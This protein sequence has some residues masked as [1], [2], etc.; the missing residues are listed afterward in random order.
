MHGYHDM[1]NIKGI[2][3]MTPT[4]DR[5]P[6]VALFLDV[7]G[8]LTTKTYSSMDQIPKTAEQFQQAT[9]FFNETSIRNLRHILRAISKTREVWIILSSSW[10]L[11][12]NVEKLNFI[13][14]KFFPIKDKT[15]DS[16]QFSP[17]ERKGFCKPELHKR[18]YHSCRAAEIQKYLQEHPEIVDFAI[19]DD[20]KDHLDI[21]KERFV[22]IHPTY[23]IT[24]GTVNYVLGHLF[25]SIVHPKKLER[26]V[27]KQH[28]RAQKTIVYEKGAP[29]IKDFYPYWLDRGRQE[30][31]R[32]VA[33]D[34]SL[35]LVYF[36][37]KKISHFQPSEEQIAIYHLFYFNKIFQHLENLNETSIFLLNALHFNQALAA[38]AIDAY[39]NDPS[40][41]TIT[42]LNEADG[43][44]IFL[45]PIKE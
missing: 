21:F 45:H 4:I 40:E 37:R 33:S 44:Q 17:E 28:D 22:Q 5:P 12:F 35:L 8:V 2:R 39:H 31:N 30:V 9:D 19:F 3:H 13:F 27:F 20:N 16:L 14:S 1:I 42:I 38:A 32:F 25:K 18:E 24:A 11:G 7:D 10:R 15:I 6:P 43:V 34:L 26:I 23:L 36:L 41:L 29:E